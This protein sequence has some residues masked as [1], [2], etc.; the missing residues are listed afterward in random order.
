M[1]QA[2]TDSSALR[3]EGRCARSR[4]HVPR[5]IEPPSTLANEATALMVANGG[6]IADAGT[7]DELH[8]GG[9]IACST[10]IDNPK[11]QPFL[12][13]VEWDRAGSG[14]RMP[15]REQVWLVAENECA[16]AGS[17]QRLRIGWGATG[18]QR[19]TALRIWPRGAARAGIPGSRIHICAPCYFI[20][21]SR[22]S[23]SESSSGLM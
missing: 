8:F 18:M 6:G 7:G 10:R 12:I 23:S 3:N 21:P 1:P 5:D 16:V 13:S 4:H 2:V 11:S 17:H 14:A 19:T 22:A 15:R 9:I 20:A